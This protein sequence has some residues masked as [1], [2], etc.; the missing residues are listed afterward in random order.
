MD[1]VCCLAQAALLKGQGFSIVTASCGHLYYL[2]WCYMS[3]LRQLNHAQINSPLSLPYGDLK[4]MW[5]FSLKTKHCVLYKTLVDNLSCILAHL[6]HG[7]FECVSQSSSSRG[8]STAE[9]VLTTTSKP[10]EFHVG[11]LRAGKR[12]ICSLNLHR[13]SRKA[14]NVSSS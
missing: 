6:S 11:K 8:N 5:S 4:V 13:C 3:S 14:C 7:S 2:K 10:A 1:R 12:I 9:M